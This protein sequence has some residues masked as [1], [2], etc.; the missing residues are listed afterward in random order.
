MSIESTPTSDDEQPANKAEATTT[1]A[2]ASASDDQN[3][4]ADYT[5]PTSDAIK[6]EATTTQASASASDDQNI[7]AESTTPTSD[8]NA[9]KILPEQ[10]EI[11]TSKRKRKPVNYKYDL[12][13]KESKC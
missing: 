12:E 2:N 6:A 1:Q 3:I 13:L 5:T 10:S 8:D 9:V 7:K 4:K 11:L